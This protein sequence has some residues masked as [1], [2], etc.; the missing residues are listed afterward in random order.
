MTVLFLETHFPEYTCKH[1]GRDDESWSK[2]TKEIE[3]SVLALEELCLVIQNISI[4]NGTETVIR[5]QISKFKLIYYSQI[6]CT[7]QCMA[8]D[9]WLQNGA[10]HFKPPRQHLRKGIYLLLTMK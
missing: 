7:W 6:E 3:Q 9:I 1:V 8:T 4:L 10:R 2:H 5:Q